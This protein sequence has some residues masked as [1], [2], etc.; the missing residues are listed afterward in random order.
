MSMRA[1]RKMSVINIA[2]AVALLLSTATKHPPFS[3]S[4]TELIYG[5]MSLEEQNV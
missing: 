5:W 3:G 4:H 2:M 1:R